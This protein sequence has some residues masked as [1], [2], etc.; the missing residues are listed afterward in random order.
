MSCSSEK[1]RRFGGTSLPSSVSSSKLSNKPA[2]VGS[3]LNLF[4]A[5]LILR[6]WR[7]RRFVPPKRQAVSESHRV[8]TQNAVL[9]NKMPTEEWYIWWCYKSLDVGNPTNVSDRCVAYVAGCMNR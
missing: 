6:L 9:F 7:W 5:E 1:G 4:L 3:K 2:E 8:R